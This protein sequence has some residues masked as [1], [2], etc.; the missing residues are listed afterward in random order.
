MLAY[1]H[2]THTIII[3]VD[4][5]NVSNFHR[6]I[7][8]KFSI[9]LNIC[10]HWYFMITQEIIPCCTC[11]FMTQNCT[12]IHFRQCNIIAKKVDELILIFQICQCFSTKFLSYKDCPMI[13]ISK[14]TWNHWNNHVNQDQLRI[15]KW[16]FW[17][18]DTLWYNVNH[19]NV[20]I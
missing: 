17:Q 12:I 11:I 19:C 1:V 4:F 6:V 7:Q 9:H 2:Y 18:C 15:Y 10:I 20:A 13:H 3:R 14:P 8:Y 5:C 16:S